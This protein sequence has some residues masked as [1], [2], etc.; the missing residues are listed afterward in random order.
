MTPFKENKSVEMK[1]IIFIIFLLPV[2]GYGSPFDDFIIQSE[3]ILHSMLFINILGIP[4]IVA[5]MIASAIFHTLRFKFVNIRLLK[6]AIA[7]LT[8]KN[9]SNNHVGDIKHFQAFATAVSGTIGLGTVAG[10]AVAVSIGGPGSV[11][12]MIIAGFLGMSS[13]FVEVTLGFKYRTEVYENQQT[14]GGPFQYIKKGLSE[15]GLPKL[16]SK[17][18]F[19][20]ALLLITAS[21]M[22]SI[23]FQANQS[24]AAITG[25]HPW[26][27]NH[28]WLTAAIITLL[29][30]SVIIGGIKRIAN[31]TSMLVPFMAILYIS[32]CFTII[33]INHENII[34]A[35]KIMLHE[36]LHG[37]AALGGFIGAFVAGIRRAVFANEA[38]IGTSAIAHA[39]TQESEPIRAGL[40]AMLEPCI[41]TMV[42]CFVTGL[43]ITVTG[44]Y[45]SPNHQ[46]GILITREA[47]STVNSWFPTLLSISVQ[48]FSFST[49]LAFAYYCEM[50]WL[51]IFKSNKSIIY[52]HILITS[53]VFFSSISTNFISLAKLGDML[54][55]CLAI[56]NIITMYLLRNK[57]ADLLNRYTDSISKHN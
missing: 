13:K 27:D 56:P 33:A 3:S 17:L 47:F 45:D 29:I 36:T 11:I 20:Y 22:G 24:I 7:I 2:P 9:H 55:M 40:V 14:F 10:V 35:F 25:Y 8:G 12:W 43:V 31:V 16:G 4:L 30:A 48:F 21:L 51:Y 18:A 54:F 15:I 49:I 44:V 32:S 41:D 28:I 34:P 23:P 5:V 6:H 26:I 39:P 38:G 1:Y 53:V 37:N 19:T 50:G 46:E 57:V 42:I 52:C